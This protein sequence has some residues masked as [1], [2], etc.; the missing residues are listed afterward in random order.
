MQHAVRLDRPV[1]AY[2]KWMA[3]IPFTYREAVLSENTTNN[4]SVER[5]PHCLATLKHIAA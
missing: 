4:P 5:D 1:K 3:R 2:G